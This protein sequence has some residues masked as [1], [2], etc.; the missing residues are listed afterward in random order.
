MMEYLAIVEMTVDAA[1]PDV[2]TSRGA[3][4]LSIRQRHG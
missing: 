3:M 2:D 1:V 4:L